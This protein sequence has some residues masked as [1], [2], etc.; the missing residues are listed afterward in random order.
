MQPKI[1]GDPVV[2]LPADLKGN[3][4]VVDPKWNFVVLNIGEKS[5]VIEDG[6]MLVSRDGKLVARVVIKKVQKD[7]CIADI[8]P[9]WK[10]GDVIEGDTVIPAEPGPSLSML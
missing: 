10:L 4:A 3:V 8:L 2:R 5:G 6:E 9:G 7:Q 1:I